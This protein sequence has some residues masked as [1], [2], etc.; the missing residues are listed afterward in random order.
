VPK[1]RAIVGE[2]YARFARISNFVTNSLITFGLWG[3]VGST[4]IPAHVDVPLHGS[5]IV[6]QSPEFGNDA[7]A[8]EDGL[9]VMV[10]SHGMASSRTQYTQYVGELASRGFVVAAIEHRDGSGPGTQV[11]KHGKPHR[12]LL[13]FDVRHLTADSGL[14]GDAFKQAQLDFRQA[15]VEETVGVLN[16]INYGAGAEIF[17]SNSRREGQHLHH[18]EGRLAI[19]NA[20]IGGHSFGA[21]LAVSSVSL[22]FDTANTRQ[23]QTL[24]NGPSK[25]LPF[26]GAVVLDP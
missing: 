4:K 18:W 6:L 3:L 12:T 22:P 19:Q 7:V 14:D 10:F 17:E 2:G 9:P 21:T 20:T 8:V 1:P 24:K 16:Q 15:E 13:H 23:L 5:S 11:I 26:Q 25:Y